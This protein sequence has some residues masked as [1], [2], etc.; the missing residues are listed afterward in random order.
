MFQQNGLLVIIGGTSIV[1]QGIYRV[2]FVD[3]KGSFEGV[4]FILGG[5]L[6]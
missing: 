4:G 3:E 6:Y 5:Y 1:G 2:S